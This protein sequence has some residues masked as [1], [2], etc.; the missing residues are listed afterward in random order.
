MDA[1]PVVLMLRNIQGTP[2]VSRLQAKPPYVSY[3]FLVPMTKGT[4][5]T[6]KSRSG[7]YKMGLSKGPRC[8]S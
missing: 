8:P 7:K 4:D 1:A 6:S 2:L 5:I 3:H